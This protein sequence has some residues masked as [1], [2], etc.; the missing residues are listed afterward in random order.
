MIYYLLAIL[1]NI[2][3]TIGIIAG[4]SLVLSMIFLIAYNIK[5]SDEEDISNEFKLMCKISYITMC[6]SW[7]LFTIIPSQKQAAFII[8]APAIVENKDLQDTLKNIPEIAKLGTEYIKEM[9]QKG[10][11]K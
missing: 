4:L 2:N 11:D 1:N 9:L 5:L 7:F 10:D 3:L 6:V 8:V